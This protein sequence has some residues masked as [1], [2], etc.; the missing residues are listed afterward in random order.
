MLR[1]TVHSKSLPDVET[2]VSF[3]TL[4]LAPNRMSFAHEGSTLSTSE[5]MSPGSIV[6]LMI[7]PEPSVTLVTWS[8]ARMRM[9][10][11]PSW[12]HVLSR[13]NETIGWVGGGLAKRRRLPFA[14]RTGLFQRPAVPLQTCRGS[15]PFL[16]LLTPAQYTTPHRFGGAY[17]ILTSETKQTFPAHQAL[18]KEGPWRPSESSRQLAPPLVGSAGRPPRC[19]APRPR[20]TPLP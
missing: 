17:R 7:A 19:R 1:I 16:L 20:A 18:R 3:T 9:S 8:A 15:P 5:M 13:F 2:T 11:R 14:R 12:S 6:P 10:L 4:S